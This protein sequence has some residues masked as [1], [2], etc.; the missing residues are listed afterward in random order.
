MPQQKEACVWGPVPGRR[1]EEKR[2][3]ERRREE[4][5]GGQGKRRD[6]ALLAPHTADFTLA[7]QERGPEEIKS[8]AQNRLGVTAV[9]L[10]TSAYHNYTLGLVA[11]TSPSIKVGR[12]RPTINLA[13]SLYHMAIGP[14]WG[15]GTFGKRPPEQRSPS[16][17]HRS[18]HRGLEPDPSGPSQAEL[19]TPHSRWHFCCHGGSSSVCRGT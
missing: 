5:R 6:G 3:E 13:L 11:R 1:G 15:R 4:R 7:R 8:G 2:G 12:D 19:V 16:S 18:S 14:G 17:G 10:Q 9:C